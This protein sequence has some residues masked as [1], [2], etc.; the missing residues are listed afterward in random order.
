MRRTFRQTGGGR[1]GEADR[2]E[3]LSKADRG[4]PL[5]VPAS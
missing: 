1:R 5:S 4:Q 2:G 3:A